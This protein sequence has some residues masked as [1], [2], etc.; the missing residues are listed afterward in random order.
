MEGK[1]TL[2]VEKL[3]KDAHSHWNYYR[4]NKVGQ[5]VA[6]TMV[7]LAG[8]QSTYTAKYG[9]A[10]LEPDVPIIAGIITT[11]MIPGIIATLGAM[12]TQGVNF[13]KHASK[14]YAIKIAYKALADHVEFANLP[15]EKAISIQTTAMTDPE[16]ALLSL[17]QAA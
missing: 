10:L 12:L 13:S 1:E 14:H 6:M 4:A 2:F 15:L 9:T 16:A 3:R 5:A 7:T 17:R 11:S 8:L